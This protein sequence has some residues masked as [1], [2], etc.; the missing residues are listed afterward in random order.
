MRL[1]EVADLPLDTDVHA[2]GL[3]VAAPREL[4]AKRVLDI[5]V[6]VVALTL[7]APLMLVVAVMVSMSSRGPALYVQERIGRDGRSINFPKFRSMYVGADE[8]REELH[9]AN[10]ADGPVF[11]IRQDPRITPIGRILRKFS[12]DELPQLLSV[13]RGDMSL[14]GPRPPLPNEV[15][16]YDDRERARLAVTP[17]LTCIWQVSGRSDLCFDEWVDMDL[18]YIRGWSLA[19]D[20][21]ILLLTLPAVISGR[22]AY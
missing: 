9:G 20:V 21:R 13:V 1:L 14:V 19:L 18:A 22:G 7:L 2:G 16:A 12:L 17:G 15:A 4:L 10:E 5:V 6:A 8:R 3:L 11:K